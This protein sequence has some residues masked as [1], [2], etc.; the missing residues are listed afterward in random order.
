MGFITGFNHHLERICFTFLFQ[1]SYTNLRH[2]YFLTRNWCFFF[3]QV[4]PIVPPWPDLFVPESP[5]LT[6]SSLRRHLKDWKTCC[7][8]FCYEKKSLWFKQKPTCFS[9]W[10]L[11]QPIWKICSS[12]WSI[13]PGKGENKKYLEPPPSFACYPIVSFTL[14][15]SRTSEKPSKVIHLIILCLLCV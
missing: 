3:H 12:N 1:A 15:P 14:L 10:W 11:N 5:H 9:S 2:S 4:I 13:S 8:L 7:W 6:P